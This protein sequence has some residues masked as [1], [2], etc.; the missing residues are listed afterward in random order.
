MRNLLLTVGCLQENCYGSYNHTD[1]RMPSTGGSYGFDSSGVTME[2]NNVS[3]TS[4]SL[5][6]QRIMS[7]AG[8]DNQEELQ[9]VDFYPS[10]R[11]MRMLDV[12]ADD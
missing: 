11:T 12:P 1:G 3:V 9:R 2:N 5:S 6:A 10:W 8:V 7:E 4:W